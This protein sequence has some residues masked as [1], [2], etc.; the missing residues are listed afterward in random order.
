M[1]A[2][3]NPGHATESTLGEA[4]VNDKGKWK[5]GGKGKTKG[6]TS[7]DWAVRAVHDVETVAVVMQRWYTAALN[8]AIAAD[9]ARGSR[10]GA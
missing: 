10:G 9:V 1:V 7:S 6:A 8:L 5:G 4:N 2:T 3:L